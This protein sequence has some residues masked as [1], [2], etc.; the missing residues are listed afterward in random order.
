MDAEVH[1]RGSCVCLGDCQCLSVS[2]GVSECSQADLRPRALVWVCACLRD[3]RTSLWAEDHNDDEPV[4]DTV[5]L[6][7]QLAP[8][9]AGILQVVLHVACPQLFAAEVVEQS[10]STVG[11]SDH[12]MLKGLAIPAMGQR[13][14]VRAKDALAQAKAQEALE[15]ERQSSLDG[16][17]DAAKALRARA[18]APWCASMAEDIKRFTALLVRVM[19]NTADEAAWR[20]AMREKV[21]QLRF[22]FIPEC[23]AELDRLM[24]AVWVSCAAHAVTMLSRASAEALRRRRPRVWVPACLLLVCVCRRRSVQVSLSYTMLTSS[25]ITAVA[26]LHGL[27]LCLG[28]LRPNPAVYPTPHIPTSS[29][30]GLGQGGGNADEAEDAQ[31]MIS[32]VSKAEASLNAASQQWHSLRTETEALCKCTRQPFHR[33]FTHAWQQ[34]CLTIWESLV[35]CVKIQKVEDVAAL[36]SKCHDVLHTRPQAEGFE[37]AQELSHL[38]EIGRACNKTLAWARRVLVDKADHA[39]R[40]FV[41]QL[42]TPH[43]GETFLP[44]IPDPFTDLGDM[45]QVLATISA[46]PSVADHPCMTLLRAIGTL[47]GDSGLNEAVDSRG[48]SVVGARAGRVGVCVCVCVCS[49]V[50]RCGGFGGVC[51]CVSASVLAAT[52]SMPGQGREVGGFCRLHARAT[53]G[54][55]RQRH[56][57]Q[58]A[59]CLSVGVSACVFLCLLACPCIGISSCECGQCESVCVSVIVGVE[60]A[61]VCVCVC[62]SVW[63]GV[64]P[65]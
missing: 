10:L 2:V 58:V 17:I 27:R 52:T 18:Q 56:G 7:R 16:A 44:V 23:V 13:L 34:Q 6:P 54:G 9:V 64:C 1:C 63:A 47:T 26:R 21:R 51:V 5:V 48:R 33:F 53:E 57:R 36:I 45:R 40:G 8:Q 22:K 3:I 31:A 14:L 38:Q 60:R 41:S 19:A 25:C 12:A 43:C 20:P 28:G 50:C 24:L 42:V 49:S 65:R 11:D 35:T 39:I 15:R 61:C 4:E 55:R 46:A 29:A 59:A 32:A 30:S 37:T 62:V